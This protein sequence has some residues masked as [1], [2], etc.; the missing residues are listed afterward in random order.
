MGGTG[1][2]WDAMANPHL[3][4]IRRELAKAYPFTR[5][6][7]KHEK[8]FHFVWAV[9]L[10]AQCTDAT[11]NEVT[12]ALFQAFPTLDSMAWARP[13]RV[14]PLVYKTGFYRNKTRHLIA[15]SKALQDK[16]QGKVPDDIASL[17]DLPGVG[18]KTANV[19]LAHL[20]GKAEGVVVDTHV[21]RLANRLGLTR[22]RDP[23]RI[24]KD[25]MKA[26]PRREWIPFSHRLI[27]HGR[28]VCD[29]RAPLCSACPLSRWC[30]SNR[31]SRSKS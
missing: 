17:V 27:Q 25:L 20:Y 23:M 21:I 19:V 9:I 28:K 5:A 8:P 12:P 16:H 2:T 15:F 24:E 1:N 14:E 22:Q 4:L 10:S 3:S 6:F 30:P 29:A 11:V 18:R 31:L 26:V 7:L 13:R